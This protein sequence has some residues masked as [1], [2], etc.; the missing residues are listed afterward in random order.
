MTFIFFRPTLF[1]VNDPANRFVF[2]HL[3]NFNDSASFRQDAT[4]HSRLHLIYLTY[5]TVWY[6]IFFN[7]YYFLM[8][9]I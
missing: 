5:F 4:Q 1:S 6:N 2:V 8:N 3:S 9:I 7:G